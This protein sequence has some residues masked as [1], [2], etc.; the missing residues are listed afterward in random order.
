MLPAGYRSRYVRSFGVSIVSLFWSKLNDGAVECPNGWFSMCKS[1][2]HFPSALST[3]RQSWRPCQTIV[4]CLSVLLVVHP[5]RMGLR[6]SHLCFSIGFVSAMQF[7]YWVLCQH[8]KW[9]WG[10]VVSLWLTYKSVN[11]VCLR[12]NPAEVVFALQL[13]V[14]VGLAWIMELQTRFTIFLA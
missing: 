2:F 3:E 13:S 4:P 8:V 6:S 12:K 5:V 10:S 7:R 9:L 14:D 1:V 11:Q